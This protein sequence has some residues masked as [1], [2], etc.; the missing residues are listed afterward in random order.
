MKSYAFTGGKFSNLHKGMRVLSPEELFAVSGGEGDGG[1]GG[2]VD[3]PIDISDTSIDDGG[4]GS[5][6]LGRVT[7]HGYSSDLSSSNYSLPAVLA[8]VAVGVGRVSAA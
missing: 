7:I 1:D 4:S 3:G 2:S 5:Y 8:L 6:D